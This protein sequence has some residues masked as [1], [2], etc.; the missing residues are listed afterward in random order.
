VLHVR[1]ERQISRVGRVSA[2]L[3]LICVLFSPRSGDA[4]TQC[5]APRKIGGW[6]GGSGD[7]VTNE[8]SRIEVVRTPQ[9]AS[10]LGWLFQL[11]N[12]LLY[13]QPALKYEKTTRVGLSPGST[14]TA[15][16][17]IR[18]GIAL[19]IASPT[20]LQVVGAINRYLVSIGERGAALPPSFKAVMTGKA[21]ILVFPCK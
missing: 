6:I 11:A 5:Y 2:A 15:D 21:Q 1:L 13:F 3:L 19:R 4:K 7:Q 8:I 14:F 20:T 10:V 16:D 18:G 17:R 12:G 9:D